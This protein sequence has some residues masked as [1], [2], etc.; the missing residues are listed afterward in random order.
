VKILG[1][2]SNGKVIVECTPQ[3][4][5]IFATVASWLETAPRLAAPAAV[6]PRAAASAPAPV[7][8]KVAKRAALRGRR[9]AAR[10]KA[11]P[12]ADRNKKCVTCGRSFYDETRTNCRKWCSAGGCKFDGGRRIPDADKPRDAS[13]RALDLKDSTTSEA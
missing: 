12:K 11:A 1:E 7:A 4:A 10:A 8:P 3:Q 13:G 9:A 6:A 2:L 5:D